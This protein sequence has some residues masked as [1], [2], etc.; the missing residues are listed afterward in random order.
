MF[1]LVATSM[2]RSPNGHASARIAALLSGPKHHAPSDSG[3]FE[4]WTKRLTARLI[5][6][7]SAAVVT[8]PAAVVA[9]FTCAD[10]ASL[11]LTRPR[12]MGVRSVSLAAMCWLELDTALRD[13]GFAV[14]QTAAVAARVLGHMAIPASEF[15]IWR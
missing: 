4:R 11:P 5:A 15:A 9:D 1:I 2:C 12:W 3:A 7:Q 10:I 8:A 6:M 13:C 14:G